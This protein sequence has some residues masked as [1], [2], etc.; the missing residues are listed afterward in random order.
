[1]RPLERAASAFHRYHR[2]DSLV[3]A[4]T[5]ASARAARQQGEIGFLSANFCGSLALPSHGASNDQTAFGVAG[6]AALLAAPPSRIIL[7]HVSI[8]RRCSTVGHRE[9]ARARHP[10]AWLNIVVNDKAS[11]RLGPRGR[12]GAA[13][14]ELGWSRTAS[15]PATRSRSA[16][17]PMRDGSRGGQLM[18]V[19]FSNGQKVCSNRGCGDGN[20]APS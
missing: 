4:P 11:L 3:T 15:R 5:N 18:S 1:M 7:R 17:G 8:S 2:G 9:A 12:L 19:K 6:I 13:I 10:H 20:P 16:I 14:A